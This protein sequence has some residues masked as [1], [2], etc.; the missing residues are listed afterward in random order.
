MEPIISNLN[1]SNNNTT[2]TLSDVNVSIAN[3]IRRSIISEIP[4]VVCKTYPE[5]E[6]DAII[7]KNTS[8]MNNEI[9]KQRLS[10]IE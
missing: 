9:V 3:G 2:F 4:V 8:R 6:N 5:N 1:V 7:N 10:C